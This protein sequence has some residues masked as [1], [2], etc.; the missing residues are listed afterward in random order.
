MEIYSFS[1]FGYEGALV[2]VEVDLRRGIPAVDVVGLADGAVKEARERMQAA[3]RNSGFEFPP[4]RVLI[5]L[6]PADLKKEGAGFDLPIALAVLA[7][8]DS[9]EEGSKKVPG[10]LN[11]SVLIMGELELSGKVRSVKG[12]H[13]ACSTAITCGITRCIVPK[14]NADEA[15][16]VSGMFVYGADNL[17]DAFE[18]LQNSAYFTS[19]SSDTNQSGIPQNADCIEGIHFLPVIEG[20][21]FGEIRG[22][23]ELIR[24]LQIA[25]AGGHNL[26]AVGAPGC[27]KTMAIQK[28]PALL[29][30]L[31]NE[32]AQSTTRIWSLA[33]L[34]SPSESLVRT[35]PFRMPHQTASIEG[36]CGGGIQCRPGEISLAHNGVL[37]LDEAAEFRTSVL[38]MLRVP[39]ES[40][41]ITL[42]RAG[43]STVY[44]ADFQL[45]MASNPCPCG[46]Y[47]S[48]AKLCLCSATAIDH[49]WKKFSSPLLDRIELR[50]KIENESEKGLGDDTPGISTHELRLP[51][52]KAVKIQ[53]TRQNKK[54]AS[55]TPEEISKYC[56]LSEETRQILDKAVARYD[57]SPRAVAGILK[58]SR[59]ISDLTGSKDI[60][61]EHLREAINFRKVYC[62]LG[63]F[64]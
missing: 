62:S 27:G 45:I 43:R 33:G 14:A 4:E 24:A 20:F 55:L 5:S 34:L 39:L 19:G 31:N 11:G 37:F 16:E 63:T 53:R 8:S 25:A 36:I 52:A 35:P 44:P 38:Q 6:S 54:N 30:L 58:V 15:R 56:I 1:P 3:I 47:G 48:T 22:Q 23:Q 21:E 9:N 50:V 7:A 12:I 57:F 42:S 29:P 60:T 59:T 28:L 40:K 49:Y 18:A 32:E 2:S 17:S 64:E 13:A 41:R 10:F 26:L 51:I 61:A 46:N